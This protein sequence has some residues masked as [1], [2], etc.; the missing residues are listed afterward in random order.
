[1]HHVFCQGVQLLNERDRGNCQ[2]IDAAQLLS[3]LNAGSNSKSWSTTFIEAIKP[4]ISKD[5]LVIF[6]D[7]SGFLHAG[8]PPLQLFKAFKSLH[9]SIQSV[10]GAGILE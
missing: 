6:D 8:L 7:Y 1:M 3:S 2:Y 5:C 4:N 9:R 10:C